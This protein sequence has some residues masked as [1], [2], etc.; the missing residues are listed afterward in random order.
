MKRQL[1]WEKEI[2]QLFPKSSMEFLVETTKGLVRE[3][4]LDNAATTT[5]F[6]A[7]NQRVAEFL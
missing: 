2:K 7:V 4:N 1:N 6:S 5:P 3:V